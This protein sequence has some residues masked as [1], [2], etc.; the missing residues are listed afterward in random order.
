MDLAYLSVA[1]EI[2]L[3]LGAVVV[4]M[5]DVFRAPSARVHGFVVGAVL[6]I[7]TWLTLWQGDRV[8]DAGTSF[9]FG[10]MVRLDRPAVIVKM[11]LLVVAAMGLVAAWEMMARLGQ[12]LAEGVSLV[13]VATAGFMLMGSSANLMMLF[14]ALEIGSISL[15]VLAGIAREHVQ[16]DEAAL[17]YFLL[18]AFASAIFVYGVALV[19][20]ATGEVNLYGIGAFLAGTIVLKPAVLLIGMSLL[21]VGMAFKVTAAPF[22]AWAPDVYQGAPAGIVGFMAAAAKIGGFAALARILTV[23]FTRYAEAWGAGIGALAALSVVLGTLLAIQQSD[24]RR[25]LAYSGVAHA[26]FILTGLTAGLTG[27]DG[28]YF[29]LGTYSVMLIGA[30]AITAVL[31]SPTGSGLSIEAFQGLGRRSPLLAASMSVF[32]LGMSGLPLTTGFVGKFTVFSDA[33]SAGFEWLVIVGLLA[34]VAGFFFYLRLIV[35]MYFESPVLAEAPGAAVAQPEA[36][37][38][39]RV[40]LVG[41]VIITIALGTF[42]GLFLDVVADALPF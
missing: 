18:G 3:V 19:Y 33:W 10:G 31:G 39:V 32:M 7:A 30:F 29:Y 35:T 16:A 2:A 28:V 20:A 9:G 37:F 40:I 6:L 38:P 11:I 4:L 27:L 1:T 23:G 12:R 41:A 5:I 8:V 25:L 13:L 21:I 22:H 36:T 15:Y 14:L 42:P 26:G 17:K 24:V 34:S